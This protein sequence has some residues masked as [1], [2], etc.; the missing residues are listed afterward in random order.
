MS[1]IDLVISYRQFSI[2]NNGLEN[3]FSN[4]AKEHIAQGFTFRNDAIGIMTINQN[5]ILHVSCNNNE[6]IHEESKRIYKFPFNIRGGH[7]VEIS[8]ITDGS[9]YMIPDGEY[10]V[11]IQL[12]N[13][14]DD[15]EKCTISFITSV[16]KIISPEVLK[17]DDEITKRKNFLLEA[18]T[19]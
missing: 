10:C 12:L 7:G 15:E 5:G 11:L 3:P 17:A 16:K 1:N 18:E 8:S 13:I 19:A 14:S 9:I 2:F 6:T 4:W